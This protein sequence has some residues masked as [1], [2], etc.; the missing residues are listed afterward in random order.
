MEKFLLD[1]VSDP[2][3]FE[4]NRLP[5]HSD[6]IAY[7]SAAELASKKSSY[8]VCLDGV[9]HFHYA[10]NFE[11]AP[12]GFYNSDYD[13][14]TWDRIR[15]PAHIQMEGYDKPQYVNVQNP[16]DGR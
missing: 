3:V 16:W 10:K 8:R 15:V 6:H 9:W 13:T 1:M 11:D 7:R 5:A 14:S 12:E 2:K 4:Q